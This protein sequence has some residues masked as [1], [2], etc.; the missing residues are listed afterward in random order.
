MV[1]EA[2]ASAVMDVFE[3]ESAEEKACKIAAA[4]EERM[5]K[6]IRCG[7]CIPGSTFFSAHSSSTLAGKQRCAFERA[8]GI[9]QSALMQDIM[10][11]QPLS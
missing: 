4:K 6:V 2:Q 10:V 5:R 7:F 1:R 8:K 9:G 11:F 3:G